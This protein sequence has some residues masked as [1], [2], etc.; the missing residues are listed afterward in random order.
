[1]TKFNQVRRSLKKLPINYTNSLMTA[2]FRSS[3]YNST[4]LVS[5]PMMS[6]RTLLKD[7]RWSHAKNSS[8]ICSS[9]WYSSTFLSNPF[10]WQLSTHRSFT[11]ELNSSASL[12]FRNSN[13]RDVTLLNPLI[14]STDHKNENVG[15]DRQMG[16]CHKFY[17]GKSGFSCTVCMT[18][19]YCLTIPTTSDCGCG[20]KLWKG[21][22]TSQAW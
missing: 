2:M 15:Y 13:Q 11:F 22:V 7:Q 1:M 3:P 14:V 20:H 10:S 9:S 18:R 21:I 19:S 4:L 17:M 16:G 6:Q 5:G 8:D 12:G